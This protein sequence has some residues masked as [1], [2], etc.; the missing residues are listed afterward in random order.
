MSDVTTVRL[1]DGAELWT[2]VSGTGGWELDFGLGVG[3]ASVSDVN[4]TPK[5]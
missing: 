5:G 1:R 3:F 2:A 4:P